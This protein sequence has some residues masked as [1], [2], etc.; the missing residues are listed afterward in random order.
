MAG[1]LNKVLLIGR[2]GADPEVKQMVN[3]KSVA[4]LSLATS[5]SWKDKNTGEKK[6][7]TEWHRIVVFNEGLVNVVQQYLKKGAQV[8][9]E[10]QLSTRKWKD[11]ATG[12]DKYSTEIVLQGYNSSLTMLDSRS[13]NNNSNLVS[14]NKSSLPNDTL[15]QDS[16]D[17]DDEIPF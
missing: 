14:E 7:K 9:V 12:Q 13:N 5:Q 15:N 8:Y 6:E 3:G 16:P 1:S 10:G 17:L 2:L 11:E 4:R